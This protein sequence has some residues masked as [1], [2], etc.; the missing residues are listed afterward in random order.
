M[1]IPC[2]K[3]ISFFYIWVNSVYKISIVKSYMGILHINS[4]LYGIKGNRIEKK[5][6]KLVLLQQGVVLTLT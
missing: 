4:L 5:Y 2:L 3:I 1:R 6:L